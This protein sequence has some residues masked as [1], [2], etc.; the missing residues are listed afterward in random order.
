MPPPCG[1]PRACIAACVVAS[2]CARSKSARPKPSV[3]NASRPYKLPLFDR[4]A[5]LPFCFTTDNSSS[6]C[7]SVGL[8]S[9]LVLVHRRLGLTRLNIAPYGGHTLAVDSSSTRDSARGL[10]LTLIVLIDKEERCLC[11]VCGCPTM[12]MPVPGLSPTPP[13]ASGSA[14]WYR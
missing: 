14:P 6:Q 12:M 10:R 3:Q 4:F 2:G 8:Y 5:I 1:G 11:F 13:S 7:V 9:S